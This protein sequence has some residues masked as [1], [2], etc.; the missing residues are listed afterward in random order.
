MKIDYYLGLDAAKHKVRVALRG[1]AERLLV[2]RDLPVS[3]GGRRELLALLGRHLPAGETLLVL[4]EATGVLHLH[5]TAALTKAGY[6]GAMKL[7]S[8]ISCASSPRD[9]SP[10]SAPEQPYRPKELVP[11]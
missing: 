4:I 9:S 3:A 6:E 11:L 2:E 1:K 10:F 5:R 8:A 7:L